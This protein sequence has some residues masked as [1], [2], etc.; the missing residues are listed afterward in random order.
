MRFRLLILCLLPFQLFATDPLSWSELQLLYHADLA[1]DAR[2]VREDD[3]HFWVR[4]NAVLRDTGFGIKAGD[5]IRVDKAAAY[6]CGYPL[7][8][9]EIRRWRLYLQK[10]EGKGQWALLERMAGSA[11]HLIRERAI[12][13]MPTR[14]ELPIA[15]F[16]RCMIEFQT[17]YDMVDST[18]AFIARCPQA[19]IDSL[20]ANN[21]ILA[22][23]E[24]QGR[25]VTAAHLFEAP[26]IPVVEPPPA[27]MRECAWLDQRPRKLG[28]SGDAND[29]PIQLSVVDPT[30]HAL[31]PRTVL[32]VVVD[33][34]GRLRD[35]TILRA[36]TPERDTAAL[37]ALSALPALEPGR[38][39]GVP[40]ACFEVFPVRFTIPKE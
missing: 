13:H 2:Y 15:E 3:A 14:V 1:I 37:R 31:E 23:F 10:E 25:T 33:V 17:C 5:A 20:A 4:V 40:T 39:N 9:G 27:P 29:P 22:Q 34:D 38:T 21:A 18:D 19:R 32:R 35:A 6:D 24:K 7:N 8:I 36:S 28:A 26:E 16:D 30:P 12:L 11:V